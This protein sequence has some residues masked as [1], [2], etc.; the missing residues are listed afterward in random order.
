V[1]P[2][3]G[4]RPCLGTGLSQPGV[5][6][7]A[8]V[9]VEVEHPLGVGILQALEEQ[10]QR[11]ALIDHVAQGAILVGFAQKRFGV[12]VV[13]EGNRLPLERAE[14]SEGIDKDHVG[15]GL[16]TD[17]L[18][19]VGVKAK[20]KRSDNARSAC[21]TQSPRST[22]RHTRHW[23]HPFKSSGI[24]MVSTKISLMNLVC[25]PSL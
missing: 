17:R 14:P 21:K 25:I 19:P 12:E 22:W 6:A 11:A 4:D 7:H 18:A 15:S 5:T 20:K 3:A 8:V 2:A 1:A 10:G 16:H 23:F 24:S 13:L 9:V